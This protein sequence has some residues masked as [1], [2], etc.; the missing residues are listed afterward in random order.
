MSTGIRA[1]GSTEEPREAAPVRI[2]G[3][4]REAILGGEFQPGDYIR[5]EDIARRLGASRLPVREALRML[6]VEGLTTHHANRGAQVPQLSMHEMDVIYQ[7]RERL[8][9][10]V[11]QESIPALAPA[12][13][14]AMHDILG[15]IE[16]GVPVNEFLVLDREFH[17]LTYRGCTIETLTAMVLRLWN[18]TQHYRRMFIQHAGPH[19]HWIVNAE[20][21]LLLDAIER[22]D[23]EGA[24]QTLAG[25]IRRTRIELAASAA[26]AAEDA[27]E[28]ERPIAVARAPKVNNAA[29]ARPL[30]EPPGA[31]RI[32]R[33]STTE[34]N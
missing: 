7:L 3:F 13:L 34:S 30:G 15:R 16:D 9:P 12:E 23:S 10:L 6:E 22:G 33:G 24:G 19:R 14:A 18:G 17:F 1:A 20:H 26:E 2:A 8:E 31:P 4:L 29:T 11:L 32:P 21:R 5:Q 27:P 25:H 28:H